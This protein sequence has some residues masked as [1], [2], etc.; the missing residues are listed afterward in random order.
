MSTDATQLDTIAQQLL[1]N[2]P[3]FYQLRIPPLLVRHHPQLER[4]LHSNTSVI[5][6][7]PFSRRATVAGRNGST[8]FTSFAKSRHFDRELYAEWLAPTLDTDLLVESWRHGADLLPSNCSLRRRVWNV[9]GIRMAA[10]RFEFHTSGDHAKWT[11]A[12]QA[13]RAN[14]I[15]DGRPAAGRP[16]DWICVGDINR[17]E[18][19]THRGGGTVCQQHPVLA[20]RYRELV[21]GY[22]PCPQRCNEV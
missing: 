10:V 9:N 3:H 7:P 6:R 11:V 22:E 5:T 14:E 15:D 2:E 8:T 1:F 4:L 20:Q 12:Q 13:N 18:R 17:G 21:A 16:D 19:Q